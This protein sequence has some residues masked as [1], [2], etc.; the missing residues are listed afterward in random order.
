VHEIPLRDALMIL[1]K[2]GGR[3]IFHQSECSAASFRYK[4]APFIGSC[5]TNGPSMT[6]S[7]YAT[8]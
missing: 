4:S 3:G 8:L 1:A 2:D 6:R 7:Q 5:T